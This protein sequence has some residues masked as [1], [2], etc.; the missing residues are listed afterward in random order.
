MCK[1]SKKQHK[2]SKPSIKLKKNQSVTLPFSLRHA[3]NGEGGGAEAGW[4]LG[5]W[6]M[7]SRTCWPPEN[8]HIHTQILRHTHTHSSAKGEVRGQRG[9][10]ERNGNYLI[11]KWIMITLCM[12]VVEK[13]HC[14]TVMDL[15]SLALKETDFIFCLLSYS[16]YWNV[17]VKQHRHHYV[18]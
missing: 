3:G 8:T 7:P 1:G 18:L 14:S 12:C 5:G 2:C 11:Q 17:V 16:S 10:V 9:W 4:W 15:I 6:M 13:S